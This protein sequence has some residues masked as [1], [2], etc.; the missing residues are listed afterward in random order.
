VALDKEEY[1]PEESPRYA[2]RTGQ[3]LFEKK[4]QIRSFACDI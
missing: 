2:L 3:R 1:L 4:N